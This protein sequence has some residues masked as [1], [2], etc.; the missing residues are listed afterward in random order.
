MASYTD[1][2]DVPYHLSH[3][4]YIKLLPET[5]C[6]HCIIVNWIYLSVT[7]TQFLDT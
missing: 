4:M 3:N 2:Q 7:T 6:V 1:L 5:V